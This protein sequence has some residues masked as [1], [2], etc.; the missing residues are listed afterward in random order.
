M[1]WAKGFFLK[2]TRLYVNTVFHHKVNDETISSIE[3]ATMM[4]L[5]P[6]GIATEDAARIL[7]LNCAVIIASQVTGGWE[8]L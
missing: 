8:Q 3:T 2:T 7:S 5:N 1:K 6:I 4:G